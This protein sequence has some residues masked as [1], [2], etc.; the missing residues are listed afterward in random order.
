M[1]IV[2]SVPAQSLSPS[3]GHPTA[4]CLGKIVCVCV[5]AW[6][7]VVCLLFGTCATH[8]EY[9]HHLEMVMWRIGTEFPCIRDA[10]T[11]NIWVK[12]GEE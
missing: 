12:C 10:V 8:Y 1:L 2:Q 9:I 5:C 11:L 4:R 6:K 3:P 7:H